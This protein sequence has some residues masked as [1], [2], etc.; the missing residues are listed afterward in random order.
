M[1]RKV[2]QLAGKTS[3]VSLPHAWVKRFG[4]K[5]GDDLEI[6][7]RGNELMLSTSGNFSVKKVQVDLT[8]ANKRVSR[9]V[10]SALHR[11]GFDEIEV[12]GGTKE[13]LEEI[14]NLVKDVMLGFIVVEQ[15][16]KKSLYKNVYVDTET[17]FDTLLRRTFLV[18]IKLAEEVK[19]RI[20]SGDFENIDGFRQQ[21]RSGRWPRENC[22]N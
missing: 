14:N 4:V 18:T 5:K 7:E 20:E 10:L 6:T 21:K 12:L 16:V 2:I 13:K 22:A 17:D 8:D 19:K 11:R 15:T 3:V 1:K 9:L